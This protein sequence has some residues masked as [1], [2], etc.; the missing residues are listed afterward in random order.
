MTVSP[1]TNF[2][3]ELK[4]IVAS[5][6]TNFFILSKSCR[7]DDFPDMA[8]NLSTPD[9]FKFVSILPDMGPAPRNFLLDPLNFCRTYIF[10]C[11]IVLKQ[12]NVILLLLF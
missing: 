2:L 5:N 9:F 11:K 7:T 3:Y 8:Y 12:S 4:I 10:L 6:R 1:R